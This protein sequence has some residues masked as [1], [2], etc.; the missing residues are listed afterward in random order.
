MALCSSFG[1]FHSFSSLGQMREGVM[2]SRAGEEKL[3]VL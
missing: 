1:V 2:E 3:C